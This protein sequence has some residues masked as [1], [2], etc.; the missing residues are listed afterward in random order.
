MTADAD[1]VASQLHAGRRRD[2]E[3]RRA[4][5]LAATL[6]ASQVV[7]IE[8]TGEERI[9]TIHAALNRLL[10]A[11]PRALNWGLRDG[12]IVISKGELP[13]RHRRTR[14]R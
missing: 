8:A 7:V 10:A 5:N 12:R 13:R 14:G 9:A 1:N 2:D 11:E 3:F 6:P 4:L